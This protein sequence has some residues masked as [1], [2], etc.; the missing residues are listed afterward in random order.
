MALKGTQDGI[1]LSGKVYLDE[2]Y[3]KV[4]KRDV[5]RRSDGKEYR[6]ISRNQICIGIAYDGSNVYCCLLGH[7]KPSQKSV[8]NGF[9]DHIAPGSTLIHDREKAHKKLIQ[10]LGLESIEYD[11]KQLKGLPDSEN[12]LEP[13]NRRCYELQRLMRRHPGFSRDDLPGYLDLFS[14][15]HNPP[16]DKYEKVENLI[17]RILENPNSLKYRD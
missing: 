7:G 12:P 8:Y 13:I 15:I 6:G 2:T 9:K 4:I 10:E 16:Q 17:K 11:P 5:E 1:I 14:Y 3:L